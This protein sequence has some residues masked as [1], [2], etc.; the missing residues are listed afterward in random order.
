[1]TTFRQLLDEFEQSAKTRRAK[2]TAFELFCEEFFRADRY[3]AAKFDEVWQWGD[4]PD[5]AGRKDTGIDLVAREADT[6]D[7]V[8]I[9]CKFYAPTATLNWKQISTFYG[10]LALS[11]FSSGLVVSTAGNES[12]ELLQKQID[13]PKPFSMWRVEDFE[14]SSVNWDRFRVDKPNQLNLKALKSL[15]PH[16]EKAVNQITDSFVGSDRGQMIMAC[17]TGKTFTSL[18]LAEQ[19]VGEGGLVL[20]MVPSINLL[21]QS[22]KAWAADAAVPLAT[23]AV[24]SDV[25]A[26]TRRRDEDMSPYDLSFPATTD[27]AKLS[28]AV[29]QV[30][31]A[32]KMTVVFSTYQSVDVISAC[33][34]AGLGRFDLIIC[35]E[36]HRTTGAFEKK[37]DQSAFTKIHFDENV[38]ADKRLYMTATPRVY[39]DQSK[40]KAAERDIL[41]ASMDDESTF[42][43]VFYELGF[44]EAV[45]QELLTDYKVL[46][47]AVN[48]DEVSAAFQKQLADDDGGLSL[49]DTARMI[50][51]WHALS[52]R[53]PQFGDDTEPM[54]RAVA[55]WTSI[56]ESTRFAEVF[57]ALVDDALEDRADGHA[58]RV[59]ADHVDGKTNVKER[60]ERIAWLE[61]PPGQGVSR[62]LTNAK[63]L[64]EG[65]DV[66]A[67]DAVMFLKPRQSIV[68]V[69]QAVGRVMRKS[70]GKELGYVILPIAVPA[71]VAPHEALKD[72]KTYKVVWQVLQA[73]RSHDERLRAEI[74]K[75]D[76]NGASSKIEVLGIGV[77]GGSQVDDPGATVT[78][79]TVEGES[80]Q[81]SLEGLDDWRDAIYVKIVERCGDRQYMEHWA[82]DIAQIAAAQE[83][84]IRTLLDH[85]DQNPDAVERFTSFHEALRNNL[86]DGVSHDDA[87]AMLSQHFITKPVFEALWDSDE[88]T[89][90]NPVSQMM[91]SMLDTLDDINLKS[92]TEALEGF[93]NH[94]RM[95]VGGI[96]NQAGRQ[97]V[98]NE[99]YEKFFKKALPK[100]SESLGI[101]YTPVEVVDFI[102]RAV[103][104]LLGRHFHGASIGDEGVH[105]LDPFTGTGTFIS[106]LLQLGLVPEADLE[107]KYEHELHANEIVLLAYYIAAINIE[108]TYHLLDQ[109][110]TSGEAPAVDYKP[111]GGIVLTD[112][113]Q[114]AEEGDPM[115]EV[116]F[117]RNNAR[118]DRQKGLD[119]RVI[120]GN[121]PYSVGQSSQNDDNQ[122]LSYPTLDASIAETYAARST[123]T[124]VKSMYDSYIRAIRWASNRIGGSP[125]G[126]VIGFV[127]NGGWIDGNTADGIRACLP[128][129]FHHLY[130]FNLRGNQRTSGEQS[131]REGG[132][133]FGSGSRN[134]V[135]ITLLVKEPGPVPPEGGQIHYCDIGDY[136]S[137]EEK[138]EIV[139]QAAVNSVDWVSIQPNDSY[140]WINQ[141]N[142]SYDRLIALAG[143]EDSIFK[144]T[145][146]GLASG[147]DSWVYNS[148]E[149]KLRRNVSSMIDFYNGQVDA[150]TSAHTS[151]ADESAADRATKAR[152]F[153]D[154]DSSRYSWGAEDYRRLASGQTKA[155]ESRM[156]TESLYRPFFRQVVAFDRSV[157]NRIY[158]LHRLYPLPSMS[159]R[160]VGIVQSGS[161]SPF[162][163][164][165]TNVVPSLHLINSDITSFFARWAYEEID[166]GALFDGDTSAAAEVIDGY[167]KV[168]NLNPAGVAR[169]A[170]AVGGVV[171]DDDVFAYVYGVLHSPDFRNEFEA[172][173][174]KEAPRVPLPPDRSTFDAFAAAGAELL[175]LHI[176]YETVEPYDLTEQWTEGADPDENPELLL[177]GPKKMRYVDKATKDALVYNP[178]LTLTGIPAQAHDYVLGT[179]SGID[180]II[181]RY[182]I[183][184]D[185][186]SG[187]VNDA[188]KWGW[189][190]G[191][192]RYIVDL[193]KRVVTV[194]VRT[195]DIVN[196]LPTL[197]F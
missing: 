144:L 112:T 154:N 122:N 118:A 46:V 89:Q 95:L 174:K 13:S 161:K 141:R 15:F 26:G 165:A 70:P 29:G 131:R 158:Q 106:R 97:R 66:P 113:F 129:E 149:P 27:P 140:D 40:A 197:T 35:D 47:L 68:D 44:G 170:E 43:S 156:I 114:L 4:W 72:N 25:Q 22:V 55:F 71:G 187:I 10:S 83:T 7:L 8:A 117:P 127:T 93:Y 2:G 6:G 194:S 150:F 12:K 77:A 120:V 98:I 115:D 90:K 101:V 153:V 11:E 36:A 147:R 103:N 171:T 190:Q 104:D 52:K 128:N 38:A 110:G 105:V 192:P 183:K 58:V 79:S 75:I 3:W 182:Y 123:A 86:N 157:N 137:R 82:D 17:G 19:Q 92:E 23:F 33:Q 37:E 9:Q 146:L 176:N 186:K 64:T 126:G 56:K 74:N 99:L 28:E 62:V 18:R 65:V 81:L 189:E 67:L 143:E 169:F 88:F 172:S 31:R 100:T 180:W 133:V 49:D 152:G 59:E 102:L 107:R 191:N 173:L 111:F 177:V 179:R 34:D 73:L 96:D 124:S 162:G 24:C 42:G 136:L 121:P 168:S 69:V 139:D 151:R 188:N 195:V 138:L 185:K 54:R 119:I 5:R 53:G 45:A 85:P 109:P 50:G 132:K 57:P 142:E 196:N 145:S 184:T 1:M 130:I 148:S 94:I 51:C 14:R 21:S 181:D 160:L 134:T 193:I 39:G 108:T 16:Q 78:T 84:R 48:Q 167:R 155:L 135:A 63:C 164:V 41:V 32:E 116:F 20:F 166:D 60:S 76:I 87:V 163:C 30:N 91:Q 175:D 61:E 159:N 125:D 80:T 178:H